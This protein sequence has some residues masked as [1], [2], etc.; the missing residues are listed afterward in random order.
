MRGRANRAQ[1]VVR[2][3]IHPGLSDRVPYI[4]AVVSLDDL[5]EVRLTANLLETPPEAVR[6]DLTW[7]VLQLKALGV[8]DVLRSMDA[9]AR[10][11]IERRSARSRSRWTTAASQASEERTSPPRNL[12]SN[13]PTCRTCISR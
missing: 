4:I 2:H 8:D 11:S 12:S 5:P 6:T 7:A 10:H 3:P 9:H 1:P 13:S